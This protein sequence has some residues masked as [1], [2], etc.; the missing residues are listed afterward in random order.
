MPAMW[1]EGMDKA[2]P[3][4]AMGTAPQPR[5]DLSL[6][7]SVLRAPLLGAATGGAL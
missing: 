2:R 5:L 1:E 4:T 3:Q 7:V 6:P